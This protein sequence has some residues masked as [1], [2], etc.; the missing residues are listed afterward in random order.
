MYLNPFLRFLKGIN[1]EKKEKKIPEPTN[2]KTNHG[3][4]ASETNKLVISA[5]LISTGRF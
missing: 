1:L 3:P 5:K 4:H 2:K